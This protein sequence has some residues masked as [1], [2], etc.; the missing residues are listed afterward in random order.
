[1]ECEGSGLVAMLESGLVRLQQL[2]AHLAM[3]PVAAVAVPS[4]GS[5]GEKTEKPKKKCI[6]LKKENAEKK[7][8]I[9]N[10]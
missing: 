7:E 5:I 8:A 10:K 4:E 6:G 3:P 1:M 2:E 9:I